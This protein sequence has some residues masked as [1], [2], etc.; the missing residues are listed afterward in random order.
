MIWV[1]E[2]FNTYKTLTNHDYSI[3]IIQQNIISLS[4]QPKSFSSG[5]AL[6]VFQLALP[7]KRSSEGNVKIVADACNL[8]YSNYNKA[9]KEI[10]KYLYRTKSVISKDNKHVLV[11]SAFESFEDD[12]E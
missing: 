12:L 7:H 8:E 6:K 1:I 11:E 3:D 5:E 10:A 4:E 2:Q 9:L